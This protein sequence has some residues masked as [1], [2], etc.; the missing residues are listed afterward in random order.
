MPEQHRGADRMK[1]ASD[2]P[3]PSASIVKIDW[4]SGRQVSDLKEILRSSE[5]KR[6]L[7]DCAPPAEVR[8]DGKPED[9]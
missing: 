8:G 4:W 3:T 7:G 5:A 2:S 1:A 9:K 6:V